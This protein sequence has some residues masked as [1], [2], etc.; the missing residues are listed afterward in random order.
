MQTRIPGTRVVLL[1]FLLPTLAAAATK[2]ATF[3]VTAQVVSDCAIAANN[4]DFGTVGALVTA[5]DATTTL[6]VTCT[7]TTPYTVSLDAGTGSGSTI[8]DRHM[9]SGGNILK[10]QMY[11]DA[12]RSQQ[13]GQTAGTDTQGGTGNGSAQV[14]TVYGRVPVQTTPAIGSYSSVVTATV[15]Y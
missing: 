7:P 2:T 6:N 1:L 12:G 13:W 11:R 4:L 8:A 5:V 10:Y 15:T 3:N 14:L 9:A